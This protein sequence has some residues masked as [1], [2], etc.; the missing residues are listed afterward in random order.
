MNE[1]SIIED[2]I[3][4]ARKRSIEPTSYHMREVVRLH[5][6]L[7]DGGMDAHEAFQ[8]AADLVFHVVEDSPY[9]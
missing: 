4:F 9:R 7:V 6:Q 2:G 5:R 8:Y 3:R 1:K